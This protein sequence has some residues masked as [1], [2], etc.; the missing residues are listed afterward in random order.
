MSSTTLRLIAVL[1]SAASVL[2]GC[3][4]APEPTPTPSAAFATEDEAFAAAE[5]TFTEY[6]AATNGTDLQEPATFEE[7]YRWLTGE[8]ATSAKE[9][10]TR[11]HAEGIVRSGDS[12]FDRMELRAYSDAQ[13]AVQLCLDVSDVAL[14]RPDGTS[15]VPPDRPPRQPVDVKLVSAPT[16]TGLAISSVTASKTASCDG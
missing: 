16:D 5:A 7:V 10:Y 13:V 15:I 12:T 3:A 11:L 6:T 14:V 2:C 1:T 9:N 8:A 4:P